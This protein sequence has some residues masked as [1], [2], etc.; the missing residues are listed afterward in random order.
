MRVI[1]PRGDNQHP[2]FSIGVMLM[3]GE[4]GLTCDFYKRSYVI[5]FIYREWTPITGIPVVCSKGFKRS[6]DECQDFEHS[7]MEGI[8]KHLVA[9][10]AGQ[11]ATGI[12]YHIC[13]QHPCR[14]GQRCES[15]LEPYVPDAASVEVQP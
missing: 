1:F 13:K 9:S 5:A 4:I 12:P 10:D 6:C 14:K 3:R 15:H 11:C 2:K 7:E 8:C